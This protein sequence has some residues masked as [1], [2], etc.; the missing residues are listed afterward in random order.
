MMMG[1]MQQ[2]EAGW[3]RNT[4]NGITFFAELDDETGEVLL[5]NRKDDDLPVKKE[6]KEF[7]FN[8]E[9]GTFEKI[10]ETEAKSE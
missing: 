10:S 5:K 9:I 4:Q 1:L 7:S 6:Q 8:V 3:Y 2:V